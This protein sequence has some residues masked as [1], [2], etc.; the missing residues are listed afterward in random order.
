MRVLGSKNLD[1]TR[2][3]F[4]TLTE[5]GT[6]EQRAIANYGLGWVALKQQHF[7]EAQ[8]IFSKLQ[9]TLPEK[10]TLHIALAET[11]TESR[12]YPE[13]LA[14]LKQAR[15]RFPNYTPLS[16]LYLST[17]IKTGQAQQARQEILPLI[18]SDRQNP[19]I[20]HLL[21][22][23][24]GKLQQPIE[25]YRYLAEYYYLT[26]RTEKAIEHIKTAKNFTGIN[27]YQ[28]AVLDQR[29]AFFIEEERILKLGR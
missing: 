11:A 23:A 17:L 21:A 18:H 25:S 15:Q 9:K 20:Y 4:L 5:Q 28:H 16:T 29:L 14:I 3:Y 6:P 10:P 26:G 2:R 7:K 8:K 12:H 24:Y 1:A 19:K 27:F 22:Q 13:T